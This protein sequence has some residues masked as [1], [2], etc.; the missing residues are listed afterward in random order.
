MGFL[1]GLMAL[2]PIPLVFAL[3]TRRG[4]LRSRPLSAAFSAGMAAGGY[5]AMLVIGAGVFAPFLLIAPAFWILLLL[6]FLI[7]VV[8]WPLMFRKPAPPDE[9]KPPEPER[10]REVIRFP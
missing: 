3:S 9:E 6:L 8:I 5:L 4:D 10:E 2:G 1:F 7:P